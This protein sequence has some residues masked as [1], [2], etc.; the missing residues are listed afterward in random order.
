M[1]FLFERFLGFLF[2][3]LPL[4]ISVAYLTLVERKVMASMQFRLGPNIVGLLG[5]LQP[6]A[7]GFKLLLK[8]SVV[9]TNSNT[10][11]F[12]FAPVL[13]LF[14][15]FLCW[16]LIPF[17]VSGYYVNIDLGVLFLLGFS[18]LAV[19]GLIISGWA[20][21]SRYAFFGALRS[22]AQMI[23]YEV[24][25]GLILVVVLLCAGSL[26]FLSIILFQK[27][28]FFVLPFLPSFFMFFISVLAETNRAPFDLPEAE[29]ELVS[30]Y[31]VE[32]ASAGFAL[33][34]LAE[35]G[36]MILVSSF[37]TIVFWGGWL[38][39]LTSS[40]SIFDPLFFSIK[41]CLI[42]FLFV[43][44]RASFPRYRLDQ[45]MRLC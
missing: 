27:S 19:Y 41:I 39:V 24:C 38:S 22:A 34:F 1:M 43:W 6:L 28:I 15:S 26:N 33:F 17:S 16:C 5:L 32:Y 8:E 18:S 2:I 29:S 40:N 3:I 4:L 30:G 11:S 13:T 10:F 37:T 45:L 21:N 25:I 36:S 7:D 14:L 23:S 9:P 42:L 31:N 44:V 12:I 35:Y 20:S